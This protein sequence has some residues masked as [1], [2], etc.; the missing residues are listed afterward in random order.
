M[1]DISVNDINKYYGSNHVLKGISF[2]VSRGDKVALLG[3]NGSGK[4]TIFKILSGSEE[5]ESGRI[6]RASGKRIE[7]LDQIPQ[8]K[9][10]CTV[11]DILHTAFERLYSLQ[12]EMIK[13]ELLIKESCS[14]T[15]LSKYGKLQTEYE[16]L[17]GYD[18]ESKIDKVCNGMNI[19]HEM[20]TQLFSKLSGGE[21]TRVN[22]ARILLLDADILLLDEPTNHLDMESIKWFEEF[23]E[24]FPGTVMVI[25]HDRC[26]LDNVIKRIIEIDDGKLSF[27]EGNYSY[28]QREKEARLLAQ[29]EKFEQQQK[30][31]SQLEKSAKRMHEWARN[32]DNPAMHKRAFSIEKRIERMERIEK[33]ISESMI[34]ADFKKSNFSGEEIITLNNIGKSYGS[35]KLFSEVSLKVHRNDRIAVVG[36]NGCGKTTLIKILTG[37]VAPDEGGIITGKSIKAQYMPQ[38]IDFDDNEATVLDILRHALEIGEERARAILAAFH[39]KGRDVFKKAGALSGG[40]K[41]RLKLCLLMQCET[42]FLILD[43]PTNHLD[44]VSREWIEESLEQYKDTLVFIS[45][46]RYFLNRFANRIWDFKDGKIIDFNGTMNDYSKWKQSLSSSDTQQNAHKG[47][48]AKKPEKNNKVSSE[49]D[50]RSAK[51]VNKGKE[52]EDQILEVESRLKSLCIDMEAAAYDVEQ[53]NVLYSEKVELEQTLDLLYRKW[54]E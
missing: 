24:N 22:L 40:E 39:F 41:S 25:S 43:E 48:S 52:I 14:E 4:T 50:T 1:I 51:A 12:K 38:V 15:L 5:F 47:K 53:L 10:G 37:E 3:K 16:A 11:E 30:K 29:K 34:T 13:I 33:P 21:K 32:A 28:Y 7:V 20:R 23:I 8:F 54:V 31:I 19:G 26:F 42:N 6:D 36:S 9:D 44:I 18:F 17:G 27:Y 35:K 2:E 46:D 49:R 45:H